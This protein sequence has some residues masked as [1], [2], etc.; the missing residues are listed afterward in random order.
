LCFFSLPAKPRA[1]PKKELL[2]LRLKQKRLFFE[3]NLDIADGSIGR[4]FVFVKK[5]LG[6]QAC[7]S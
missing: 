2:L 5:I 7:F 6:K 4:Q 1:F 3:N